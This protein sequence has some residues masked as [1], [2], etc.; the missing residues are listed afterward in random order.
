ME[1]EYLSVSEAAQRVGK[2]TQY[3][4][5]LIKQGKLKA[6]KDNGS[7]KVDL[8]NLMQVFGKNEE[9]KLLDKDL[10]NICQ[11][12]QK[13]IDDLQDQ[14]KAKD[15]QIE[16]LQSELSDSRQR[17]DT[18][19]LQLTRQFE[20]QTVLLEDMR[21]KSSFWQRLKM[22]VV[23]FATPSATEQNVTEQRN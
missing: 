5:L 23:K 1:E 13:T 3:L 12:F 16:C 7:Y 22:G 17:S 6:E 19:I 14:L 8:A 20:Q 11:I 4:Y 18:I 2:T 10:T 9:V 21:N 15:V